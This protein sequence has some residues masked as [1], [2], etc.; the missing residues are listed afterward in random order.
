[1]LVDEAVELPEDLLVVPAVLLGL[2]VDVLSVAGDCDVVSELSG[3]DGSAVTSGVDV[4]D[5]LVAVAEI[6]PI[7]FS[8]GLVFVSMSAD[9]P[10]AD[11]KSKAHSNI[12]HANILRITLHSFHF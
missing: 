9:S 7:S 12:I 8:P 5:V 10:Q 11:N 2:F 3:V 1:M 6:S 4:S